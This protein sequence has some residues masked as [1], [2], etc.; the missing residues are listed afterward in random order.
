MMW[1]KGSNVWSVGASWAKASHHA[2]W[3][4]WSRRH[5]NW[6]HTDWWHSHSSH[7]WHSSLTEI[8]TS[9]SD[10]EVR[11]GH[12]EFEVV[13]NEVKGSS[14]YFIFFLGL[15]LLNLNVSCLLFRYQLDNKWHDVIVHIKTPSIF[16]SK[17]RLNI[18]IACIEGCCKELFLFSL[19]E[20]F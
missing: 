3:W 6:R 7:R 20:E 11:S 15:L 16:E 8:A 13:T 2:H 14:G 12:H 19:H 1:S 9:S 18:V 4:H 17:V 5:S 10:H